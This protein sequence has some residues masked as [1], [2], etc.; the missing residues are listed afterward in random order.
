MNTKRGYL[1]NII[2]DCF[3]EASKGD[4]GEVDLAHKKAVTKDALNQIE[5]MVNDAENLLRNISSV[6][7]LGN[8]DDALEVLKEASEALY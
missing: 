6:S 2:L 8:V 1:R 7:D 5:I 4:L 3:E